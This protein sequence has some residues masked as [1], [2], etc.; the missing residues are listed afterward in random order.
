MQPPGAGRVARPIG[1]LCPLRR[2]QDSPPNAP[3]RSAAV[4]LALRAFLILLL[5]LVPAGVVQV[6]LERE[7]R[8]ARGAALSLTAQRMVGNLARQQLGVLEATERTLEAMAAH[9]ALRA[10]APSAACDAFVARL[11]AATPRYQSAALLDPAGRVLCAAPAAAEW[12]ALAVGPDFAAVLAGAGFRVAGHA[13]GA[14]AGPATLRLLAPV[15]GADGAPGGVLVLSL[16]LAQLRKEVEALTW[17]SDAAATIADRHGVVLAGSA[18]MS[19]A[20]GQAMP[21][22]ARALVDA[23]AAGLRDGSA[24]DGRHRIVAF[25]PSALGPGGLFVAVALDGAPAEEAALLE[26]RRSALVIVGSLLLT[27]VIGLAGFHHAVAQPVQRLVGVAQRWGRQEWQARVGAI[28]G[29]RE[30]AS[31]GRA[32][33][34]MAE[35]VQVREAARMLAITRLIAVQEVAPQIVLTADRGG[36]VDWTNPYWRVL[37]GQS[38]AQSRGNGW[39][40]ALHPEDCVAMADAWQQAMAE[41][42]CGASTP[43][44][45]EVRIRRA[46]DGAW[47]WFLL[48]GAPV[49]GA[50]GTPRAWTAVGMDVDA[51]R[52][53]Q[54]ELARTAAQLRATY[55]NAPA[56]LCLL[57]RGL[58]FVAVNDMLAQANARGSAEHI[59]RGLAEMAPDFAPSVEPAMRQVLASGRP[60]TDL[61][62]RT[63]QGAEQR[64]WLCNF[65]PVL[66][67]DF[68]VIGVSGAIID[69]TARQ[70]A[71]ESERLLSREVDHRAQNALSVVRGLLRLSAADA[72]DDVPALVEVL[73]GRIGAMSRAHNLLAREKWAAADLREIVRQELASHA[74]QT[75]IEGPALRL[76]AEA[77][78]PLTMVLHELVTNAV[79]YGA[80]SQ[81][82]GHV[83]LRWDWQDGGVVLHWTELGGPPLDGPPARTGFGSMLIDANL[84]AQLAGR[85]ERDWRPEGLHCTLTFGADA[86][87]GSSVHGP[88]PEESAL[89][90]RRVLLALDDPA[91]ALALA[92]ALR[93]VGCEVI[94]PAETPEQAQA[95]LQ[96]SGAVDAAVLAGTLRGRAVQP[97]VQMLAR[98]TTAVIYVSGIGVTAE[99][100]AKAT[101][102]AAPVTGR[103]LRLALAAALARARR[104]RRPGCGRSASGLTRPMQRPPPSCVA[105]AQTRIGDCG[106]RAISR[107]TM[108][109]LLALGLAACGQ[110]TG[111]RALSGGGIGAAGGAVI[112]AVTGTSVLGGAVIGGAAGAAT[113]ALTSPSQINLGR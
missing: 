58:R 112:G 16:S 51:L 54:A 39:L 28:G 83:A 22:Q 42:A 35:A 69:I 61:E 9:A 38:E 1:A 27:F 3:S 106:M 108:A 37:T 99:D 44:E 71:D 23:T 12:G 109:A 79:K 52:A 17:P 56:G 77:A 85:I 47:R 18:G 26:D 90:G 10:L 88:P 5:A 103:S 97:V 50:D 87:V 101:L 113:G 55:E 46:A 60:V 57:D 100:L 102:L 110:N 24:W 43:F 92:A 104:G 67:A 76:R 98:R 25:L 80:L 40:E 89:H 81:R 68:A 78:Q 45:R 49:Q 63:G 107:V 31:L 82:A 2:G 105:A 72:P 48:R 84:R 11:V 15:A 6:L 94:G 91:E 53:T 62:V 64:S 36:G 93:E 66:A 33:D 74:E 65:H 70:R 19:M 8:R 59:G 86:L 96:Q 73:E 21:Q 13:P 32:F 14:G 29:G 34:S 4:P 7:A 111:E 95:L 30:F 20:V 75:S 41:A